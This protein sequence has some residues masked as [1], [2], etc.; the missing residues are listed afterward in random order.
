MQSKNQVMMFKPTTLSQAIGLT[1]LQENI[2]KVVMKEATLS[3]ETLNNL[4]PCMEGVQ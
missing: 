2:I 1:L 4:K 3:S